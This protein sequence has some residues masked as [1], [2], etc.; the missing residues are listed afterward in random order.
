MPGVMGMG[1]HGEAKNQNGRE[2]SGRDRIGEYG[3]T[4]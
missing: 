3:E 2:S 1:G 4:V